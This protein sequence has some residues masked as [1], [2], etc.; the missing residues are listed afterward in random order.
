M[1]SSL[2]NTVYIGELSRDISPDDLEYEFKRFGQ[3]RDFSFKGRYA[4]VEYDEK[5]DAERA[6]EKMDRVRFSGQKITVEFASKCINFEFAKMLISC[7]LGTAPKGSDREDRREDR[8]IKRA[9]SPNDKCFNCNRRGH[10]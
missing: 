6:I 9:P 2:G 7:F 10:W 5:H 1:V 3:V 4:F 8:R